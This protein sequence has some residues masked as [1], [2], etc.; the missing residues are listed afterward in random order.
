MR[1]VKSCSPS[2]VSYDVFIV[3][4]LNKIHCIIMA[5]H[6]ILLDWAT[7]QYAGEVGQV[8]SKVDWI[9]CLVKKLFMTSSG[10]NWPIVQYA[11]NRKLYR[12]WRYWHD[13]GMPRKQLPHYWPFVWG[14]HWSPVDSPHKRASDA[15]L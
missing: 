9:A 5:S 2:Q 10:W 7:A 14:I 8:I 11:R 4:I 1:L 15:E 3:G 6:C 13:D 12:A